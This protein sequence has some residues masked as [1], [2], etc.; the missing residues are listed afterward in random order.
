MGVD[1][2]RRHLGADILSYR[3]AGVW[4]GPMTMRQVRWAFV[5]LITA[6]RLAAAAEV[7]YLTDAIKNPA[8]LRALTTLLKSGPKLPR[9]TRQVLDRSGNYVGTPATDATVGSTRY[10]LFFTC[11]A[12]DCDQNNLE[13]MFAPD[14]A[15]AWG[16]IVVDGRSPSYL[17]APSAAQQAALKA[18]LESH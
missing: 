13:I 9:W 5:V 15:Q 10:Q 11:K 6:C 17:G 18:A 16:A 4:A 3:I 14:G 2:S 1:E 12:H 7:P 8:Y